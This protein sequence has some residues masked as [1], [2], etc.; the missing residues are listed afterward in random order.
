MD[1]AAVADEEVEELEGDSVVVAVGRG[2]GIFQ[3]LANF[4]LQRR[5]VVVACLRREDGKVG[6]VGK[7][8]EVGKVF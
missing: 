5:R 4:R 8:G 1:M 2:R 3:P 7:V 6:K